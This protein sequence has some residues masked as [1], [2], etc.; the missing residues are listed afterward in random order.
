MDFGYLRWFGHVV[1]HTHL[2]GLVNVCL[3]G[4]SA[5]T[6]NVWALV[7]VEVVQPA[8]PHTFKYAVGRLNS[9]YERH[10]VVHED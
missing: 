2:Q 5:Q 3:V 7:E 1:V 4:V 9:I 8:L 10:A 6:A